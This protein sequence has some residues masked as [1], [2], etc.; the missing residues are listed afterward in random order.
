MI[1]FV[2]T[3]CN[4]NEKYLNLLPYIIKIWKLR[5]N[6][7]V[8]IILVNKE[9]PE[10]YKNYKENIILYDKYD[11]KIN[12]AYIAQIIRIFYPGLFKDKN[13]LITDMDIMPCKKSYFINDNIKNYNKKTFITYTDRYIKNNMFAI[14]Y[15]MANSDL[16]SKIFNINSIEDVN[17]KIRLYYNEKYDG[18]K[19]CE[20]WF[21]DQQILYKYLMEYKKGD[22]N[23]LKIL[24]DK[25]LGYNRLDKSQKE[26]EYILANKKLIIEN[27]K[28]ELYSDIHVFRNYHR[29][30]KF[31]E[32]IINVLCL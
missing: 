6:L 18:S 28:N 20:G 14:C 3:A 16:W 22:N 31:L 15:N 2:L 9:I 27:I 1:D 24:E 23:F 5:F 21:S 7:D 13:I 26:T 11:E 17:N 29:H 25:K 32:E 8:K 12:T 4:N 10:K 30:I 19:N